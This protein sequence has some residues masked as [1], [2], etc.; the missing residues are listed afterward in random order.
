[1]SNNLSCFNCLEIGKIT[2]KNYFFL[3]PYYISIKIIY[4]KFALCSEYFYENFYIEDKNKNIDRENFDF[5]IFPKLVKSF[6]S[7]IKYLGEDSNSFSKNLLL[8]FNQKIITKNKT[9]MKEI[10]VFNKKLVRLLVDLFFF[11]TS[12]N[13]LNFGRILLTNNRKTVYLDRFSEFNLK[14]KEDNLRTLFDFNSAENCFN[15]ENYDP[16]SFKSF[17][18]S[19]HFIYISKY[20]ISTPFDD[21]IKKIFNRNIDFDAEK[22]FDKNDSLLFFCF[23]ELMSLTKQFDSPD[24]H[25]SVKFLVNAFFNYIN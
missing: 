7:I 19:E 18:F 9:L 6:V 1:M 8:F 23:S 10:F 5:I 13:S 21:M 14:G 3:K 22:V 15:F 2:Q 4:L 20:K 12:R 11:L 24:D 16:K 25:T 17:F